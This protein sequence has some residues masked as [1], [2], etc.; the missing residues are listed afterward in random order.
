MFAA[1]LET[2]QELPLAR[3]TFKAL[4]QKA[5]HRLPW[6]V[7]FCRNR[8]LVVFSSLAN[9]ICVIQPNMPLH[10]HSQ[11][12]H[13]LLH[14]QR[15]QCTWLHFN[16][17][18]AAGDSVAF[19]SKPVFKIEA[20]IWVSF[21]RIIKFQPFGWRTGSNPQRKSKNI[22]MKYKPHHMKLVH[23]LYDTCF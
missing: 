8:N 7:A 1:L 22:E 20:L 4:N 9:S 5:L 16:A 11:I 10:E 15:S 23:E 13:V 21:W 18:T 17:T 3:K 6:N 12:Q 2:S 19:E 14:A